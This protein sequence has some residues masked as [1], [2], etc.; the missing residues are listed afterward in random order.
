MDG[1]RSHD[2]A[3]RCQ[4]CLAIFEIVPFGVRPSS[5]SPKSQIGLKQWLLTLLLRNASLSS[6]RP[7][8]P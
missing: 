6:R 1:G 4:C 8:Y 5:N 3:V 7:H 2:K